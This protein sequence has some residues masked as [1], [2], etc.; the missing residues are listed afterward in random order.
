MVR[1]RQLRFWQAL[2]A[3]EAAYASLPN[4]NLMQRFL[5]KLLAL[6]LRLVQR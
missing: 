4:P 2:A 5:L 6:P 1:L 3:F